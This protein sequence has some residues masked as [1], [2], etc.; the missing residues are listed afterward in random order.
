MWHNT[1]KFSNRETYVPDID[2]DSFPAVQHLPSIHNT[3]QA[4][5]THQLNVYGT[6]SSTPV[7]S[8]SRNAFE[9]ATQGIYNAGNPDH[10]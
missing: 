7:A 8:T 5:T 10:V 3:F 6:G 1:T 4:F 2:N 9:K